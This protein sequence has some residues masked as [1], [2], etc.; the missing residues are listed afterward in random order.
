MRPWIFVCV[1]VMLFFATEI[2]A[3]RMSRPPTLSHP[4]DQEQV[5]QLNASLEDIFNLTNGKFNLDIVTTT[6]TDA[7]NG[8]IWIRNNA[9]TYLLE[10]KAGDA[11]RTITP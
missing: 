6:K 4:I 10:F 7:M 3:F 8:D 9:G 5:N 1:I 11:V 2:C